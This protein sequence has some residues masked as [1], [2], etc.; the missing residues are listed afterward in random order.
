MTST[1]LNYKQ[2]MF[3]METRLHQL[4]NLRKVVVRLGFM[5]EYGEVLDEMKKMLVHFKLKIWNEEMYVF[6]PLYPPAYVYERETTH[7]IV[8]KM[9]YIFLQTIVRELD[10]YSYYDT[11]SA[12]DISEIANQ[13]L[14]LS[15]FYRYLRLTVSEPSFLKWKE[16][17]NKIFTPNRVIRLIPPRDNQCATTDTCGIC[18]ES[19]GKIDSIVCNC[20][21]EF[22]HSCFQ[23]WASN[24]RTSARELTCPTCRTEVQNTTIFRLTA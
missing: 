18:L 17:R 10:M 22:G 11:E 14:D 9:M 16:F 13:N 23:S 3:L 4:A 19:H 15:G 1:Q 5:D 7:E 8:D 6:V 20:L 21:H 24:C 12:R 2:K